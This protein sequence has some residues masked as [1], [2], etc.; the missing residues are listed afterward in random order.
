MHNNLELPCDNVLKALF[1][2][3]F[4]SQLKKSPMVWN[5]ENVYGYCMY[6]SLVWKLF[7]LCLW[8]M[9]NT[10]LQRMHQTGVELLFVSEA[11]YK[12]VAVGSIDSFGLWRINGKI[13]LI[14]Y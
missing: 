13:A 9:F 11:L 6:W 14:F 7:S 12:Q 4:E 5:S 3:W 8:R 10:N 1:A 2:K